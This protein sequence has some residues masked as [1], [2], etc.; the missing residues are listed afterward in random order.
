[1][2][3]TELQGLLPHH[4]RE[5]RASGLT[6]ATITAAGI[7]SETSAG[8][9][10]IM[11]NW[12]KAP[13]KMAPAIVYPFVKADG[14]NGFYRVKPDHPRKRNGKPIKYESPVGSINDIYLPPGVAAKLAEPTQE[15]VITEGEKKA[16]LLAQLGFTAIGLVGVFG[17]KAKKRETLIAA[18]E[19]IAWQGRPVYL[20]FDSDRADNANVLD[21]ESRLSAQIAARGGVPKSVILPP[22]PVGDDGKPGKVG[23]DDHLVGQADARKEFRRLLDAAEEPAPVDTGNSRA[24]AGELDPQEEAERLR[25]RESIDGVTR[26]VYWGGDVYR[27]QAGRHAA[28]PD[29]DLRPTVTRFLNERFQRVTPGVTSC[30][31]EQLRAAV[32]LFSHKLPPCWIGEPPVEW[33][34]DDMLVAP[35]CILH[36]PTMETIPQTPRLFSTTTIGCEWDPKAPIP[37]RWLQFVEQE[38]FPNDLQS[39]EALQETFGLM[40]VDDTTLQKIVAMIGVPRSGKGVILRVLRGLVGVEN[41]AAPTLAHL[42]SQ[43]GLACLLGKRLA[44]I[45]DARIGSR[46]DR[47]II[48]ERLL[49]ISGEDCV[50]IDRKNRSTLSTRLTTRFVIVSNELPRLDD[51]SGAIVGRV[52]L[53]RFTQSFAG[54]EDPRL[55]EKLLAELPGILRWSVEGL[56][57]L[58]A[59]GR[60]VQ[61]E[62]ALGLLHD[63]RDSASPIKAFLNDVCRLD[64][65]SEVAIETLYRRWRLWCEAKGREPGNEQAFGRH[66]RAALP[67]IDTAQRK[68]D[69]DVWRVYKGLALVS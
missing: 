5:L 67:A 17:W 30:V 61:P 31:I 55:T 68:K 22:G 1:M 25:D 9:L 62:S 12:Q 11:L 49:S 26:L 47:G 45:S 57:R 10:A 69:G 2:E 7:R 53:L 39:V 21:G 38:V 36:L 35:N 42:D 52:V 51:A 46:S 54:R 66:L 18:L 32:H 65:E 40:M 48:L 24:H 19:Q 50:E 44:V 41:V 29:E 33:Q 13:Q 15:I 43:F 23:V 14:G 27:Y 8:K 56:K 3:T 58:R 64:P 6:D 63:F 16:L 4:L 34:P 37:E 28:V 59:R 20:C 60:F